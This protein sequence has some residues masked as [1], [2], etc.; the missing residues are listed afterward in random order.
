MELSDDFDRISEHI[1]YQ[2]ARRSEASA[3]GG[4]SQSI[5]KLIHNL[6]ADGSTMEI[7]VG[8][9]KGREADVRTSLGDEDLVLGQ[10]SGGSVVFAMCD[11]PRVEWNSE[12]D[13]K[14][15]NPVERKGGVER[16][17]QSVGSSRLYC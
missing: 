14:S 5:P 13:G 9:V 1:T 4:V 7:L 6:L 15:V 10:M 11:T 2:I 12:T 8:R 17:T 16:R 3:N